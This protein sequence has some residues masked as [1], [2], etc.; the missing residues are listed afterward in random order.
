MQRQ[1]RRP[2]ERASSLT[3]VPACPDLRRQTC[4]RVED[5]ELNAGRQ[6]A[7]PHCGAPLW[8]NVPRASGKTGQPTT[9]AAWSAAVEQLTDAN[10][11]GPAQKWVM[12]PDPQGRKGN[13]HWELVTLKKPRARNG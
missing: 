9:F 10:P 7:C 2:L 3:T 5:F 12:Q 6:Q 1:A 4:G 8:A 11:D 13:G